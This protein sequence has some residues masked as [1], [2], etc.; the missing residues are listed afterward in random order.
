RSLEEYILPL[1]IQ[2]LSD[3]EEFVVEKVLNSLTSL[4]ELGLFQKMKLWELVAIV[5]PLMCHPGVWIRY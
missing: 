4:A 1:M 3:S 2:S 5:T